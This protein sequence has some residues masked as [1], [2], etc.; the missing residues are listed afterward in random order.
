MNK[1]T[2]LLFCFIGLFSFTVSAQQK[3]FLENV[4]DYIENINMFELNQEPG[5]V[6]LMIYGSVKDAMQNNPQRSSSFI[7]LNGTWKFNL[8]ENPDQSPK[9][10]FKPSFNDAQWGTIKVPSNWQMQGYGHPM[11]RNVT[12]LF[13][14]NPPKIPH[15][16][17]PVGSYRRT[18]Q[19]PGDWK[20]KQVLLRLEAAAS[21]SF[22]WVNGREVG[23]NQGAMEPAEYDI[24]KYIK[25]GK[26]SL[27]INV[28]AYSDGSYLESQDM[29]RLSGI[30]R[31]VSLTATP[32]IHLR[33]YYVVTDLDA[34]YCD[35]QLNIT[36]ELK[37]YTKQSVKGYSVR[38]SLYDEKGNLIMKPISSSTISLDGQQAS[39]VKISSII[40]NP[41]KWSAEHPNLYQ[42][43]LELITPDSKVAEVYS[44]KIGFRK[45]EVRHQALYV[46][47]VPVKLN[48]VNSHMQ[49]PDTGHAMDVETIRKDLTLMKQFNINCVRT[50]HYPP[51]IEYLKMAD[52]LGMYIVDETGDEAHATEYISGLP[53]WR[54]QYVERVQKMVLRDRNHPSIIIWSAGNESG[55]GNNICAVIEE[56]KRL[57]PSRPAWMYGGNTTD[58]P[59]KNPMTCEDIIGP[60]YATPFE[61]KTLIGEVPENIDPRPSF[62]DEYCAATG[63]GLGG[64]DEYWDVI[65]QYPRCIGGA[66]WDWVSPALRTKYIYAEDASPL[67]N[68]G[69]II[70]RAKLV[71]GKF[72]KA[73]SLS[74][75]DEFVEI[76]RDPALDITGKQLTL[77]CWLRPGKWNG[78]G[79]FI[80]KGKYQFGLQQISKDTLEFYL[81]GSKKQQLHAAVPSNWEG[82]WHHLAATYNG[83]LISL[84]V[85]G[86]MVISKNYTES[87]ENKPFPVNIGRDA[88]I[89]GQ[90]HNGYLSNAVIDQVSIFNKVVPIDQLQNP[91]E[92]LKKSSLLWLD[93]DE[94]KEKGEFFSMGIGGRSYGMVWPDRNPQ[95][96]LW[97]AKKSAQ[98]VKVDLIDAATGIVEVLNRYHFTNLNEL[99][100]VWQLQADG[101]ILQNGTLNLSLAP[102]QKANVKI[103]FVKP[104]ILPGKEYR[105]LV[106]FRLKRDES[107]AKKGHEVAWDQLELPYKVPVIEIEK[108]IKAVALLTTAETISVKGETFNY[109]LDKNTGTFSSMQYQG[110]ELI[111][112]GP[113]LNV[114]RAS[115]ANERDDWTTW[116]ANTLIKAEGMGND[117]A[118]GW[119]TIGLDRLI[120]K[121]DRIF[122][123]NKPTGEVVID[124]EEHAQA[125]DYSTAFMNHYVYTI[126]GDGEITIN[127]TVTPWGLM[128][129]WIPKV[130]IQLILNP[131]MNKI[132]W[133]GRGPIE[134][135]P[136]RKT[137]AKIGVYASTVQ[138]E[139]EPYVIPQDYGNKTDVRWFKVE[140]K[141]GIGLQ[142]SGSDLFNCSAQQYSTDNLTRA[143]YPF[144]LKPFNGITLNVDYAL[145]GVGCTAISVLNKYRVT[146]QEYHFITKLKPYMN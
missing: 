79:S 2:L 9:D 81:T 106:S 74:G 56:G 17:N 117:A 8:S 80:T 62:M 49:H 41:E 34:S 127:H 7:S 136:D 121:V 143:V 60:R 69:A 102:L 54:A 65:Y 24:T 53:E 138:D 126:N 84:Y 142:I 6:P 133:Y 120:H 77:S 122:T 37:N 12:Q 44:E 116:S 55:T 14:P 64:M 86:A 20:D 4:Y 139:Y 128:P 114:W 29:W 66:I 107:W 47:G 31:D 101:D 50:S 105:L 16:Y 73:L 89:H 33:D 125:N 1:F 23:Y 119:R 38:A 97:Q 15:D 94:L 90:E 108:T 87:I 83:K 104:Q 100:A 68:N 110:K 28:Y 144:Q 131:T 70:G 85:D 132:A 76:Y 63:N 146:P 141:E 58:F 30:F 48:G 59:G 25:P 51:N 112:Q 78:N 39:Q 22:I 26:N 72:G 99:D 46:N 96:E 115:V 123:Q 67:K 137:G 111:N 5:H 11:F 145:S 19:I 88:E 18:F 27:A 57:D 135:Y 43:V 52:E 82:A 3:G 95:P 124:V 134:T 45:V 71:D 10:F 93:F 140:S 98:P 42:L 109:T 129:T 40:Q 91:V 75:H 61:L 103:P 130:G 36:T 35:A 118:N 113:V 13:K 92:A 32:K 21:A